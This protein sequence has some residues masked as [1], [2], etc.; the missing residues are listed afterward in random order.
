MNKTADVFEA[1]SRGAFIC[2]NAV[3]T[4]ER[5]LYQYVEEHE[6]RLRDVFMEIGYRLETGNNY[7]FFSR[8]KE[9]Q[10]SKER[11]VEKALRWLDILAFFTTYRKDLCR[12]ARF[13]P[14]EI[15]AQFDVNSSLKDQLTSLQ[16]G[17]GEKNYAEQLDTLLGELRREGFIELENEVGQMWKILDAWDYLERMVMAVNI[18]EEEETENAQ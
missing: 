7:Y 4:Q 12:G 8:V 14:H 16:R 6:A 3:K 9:D 2:S 10:Q 5:Y 17:R 13:S 18:F 15:A 11:K 1:L